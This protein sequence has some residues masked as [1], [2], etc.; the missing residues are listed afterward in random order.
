[1][2][3][4]PVSTPPLGQDAP[5]APDYGTPSRSSRSTLTP[6]PCPAPEIAL[7]YGTR[8]QVIKASVLRRELEAGY[9]VLAVD[10]G[11]HYDY[12]LNALLY[13][14]LGV[15]PPDA[16]LEV[17]SAGHAEQTARSWCAPSGAPGAP[18]PGRRRHRRYQLDAGLRPRRRQAPHPGRPRRGRSPRRRRAHGRGDQPP[19]GRRDRP[20]PLHPFGPRHRPGARPSGATRSSCRP[21]TSPTTSCCGQADRLP[22]TAG[23]RR[24]RGG[25]VLLRHACTAPS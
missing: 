5:A 23:P 21:A 22:R 19:G 11:Q 2:D 13:Q 6:T 4:R 9:E 3:A 16:L 17:G 10:T 25:A 20:G 7:C 8:P 24:R 15:R 14:Q 18:A 12:E 1:M